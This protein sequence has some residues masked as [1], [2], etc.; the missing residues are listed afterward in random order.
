MNNKHYWG[1]VALAFFA[2]AV[3][4]FAAIPNNT[5]QDDWLV[6]TNINVTGDYFWRNNNITAAVEGITTVPV[7]EW[8]LVLGTTGD[9]FNYTDLEG[10]TPVYIGLQMH[11]LNITYD[12][13]SV[14]PVVYDKDATHWQLALYWVNGT[15]ITDNTDLRVM[16]YAHI[17]W[18]NL[19]G[20][21]YIEAN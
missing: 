9:W 7:N 4:A 12:S 14:F 1:V 21:T 17:D 13:V 2:T 10:A 20:L 6:I 8:G 3:V 15:Q 5:L 11:P 19:D 16:Y 18:D